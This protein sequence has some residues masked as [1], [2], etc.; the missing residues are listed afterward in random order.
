[1]VQAL[2]KA[3]DVSYRFQKNA[4]KHANRNDG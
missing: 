2:G 1:L 3:D 4:G